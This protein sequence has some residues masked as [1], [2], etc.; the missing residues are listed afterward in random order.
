MARRSREF[1]LAHLSYAAALET[2]NT[3]IASL[4]GH[5]TEVPTSWKR[6]YELACSYAWTC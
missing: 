1:F 3:V 2:V 6:A 5:R 4:E